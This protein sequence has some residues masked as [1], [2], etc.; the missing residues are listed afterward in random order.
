M[1]YTKIEDG[2]YRGSD[3]NLYHDER[4]LRYRVL[5]QHADRPNSENWL[6]HTSHSKFESAQAEVE[7]QNEKWEGLNV[8]KLRDAGEATNIKRLV[9]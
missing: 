9:Y 7:R 4:V 5:Y 6:L 1:N 3:G 8:Y 2:M